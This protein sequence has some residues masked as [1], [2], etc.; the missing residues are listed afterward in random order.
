M[1]VLVPWIV[2]AVTTG[3]WG[4]KD[5]VHSVYCVVM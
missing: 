1:P 3:G 2:L 5:R 4:R